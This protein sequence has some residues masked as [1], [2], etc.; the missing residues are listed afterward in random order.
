MDRRLDGIA[1]PCCLSSP[2]LNPSTTI[3]QLHRALVS[4][5]QPQR[6]LELRRMNRLDRYALLRSVLDCCVDVCTP[7]STLLCRYPH[8]SSSQAPCTT[9]ELND[10]YVKNRV[11]FQSWLES[12]QPSPKT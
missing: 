1:T 4:S 2:D 5:D 12:F 10:D 6:R 9:S 3:L 8:P 7:H 11:H